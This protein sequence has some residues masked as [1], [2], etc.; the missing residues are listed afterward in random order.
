[1]TRVAD[2]YRHAPGPGD[3]EERYWF[4]LATPDLGVYARLSLRPFQ[5]IAWWWAALVRPGEA[6]VAIRADDVRI[7]AAGTEIRTDG[8]WACVTCETPLEHWSVGLEAY[9]AAFDDPLEAWGSERGDLVPFGLD[10]EWEAIESPLELTDGYAQECEVHGDVL[11]GPERIDVGAHGWR[12]HEWGAPEGP[13]WRF[14]GSHGHWS[15][16]G[17]DPA[18]VDVGGLPVGTEVDGQPAAILATSPVRM[19][20]LR[21]VHGLYRTGGGA[22]GWATWRTQ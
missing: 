15:G 14:A 7:P 2:E 12:A 1:M 4:D 10:L 9:G 18:R 19:P 8:I 22:S 5:G 11:L 20:G 16:E 6:L 13:G 3:W 17:A 21:V